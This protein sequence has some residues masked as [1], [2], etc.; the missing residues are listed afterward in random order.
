VLSL[1]IRQTNDLVIEIDDVAFKDD[2]FEFRATSDEEISKVYIQNVS[3]FEK[4]TYPVKHSQ[5][6]FAFSI[7]YDDIKSYPIRKWELK[8]EN[9]FKTLKLTRKFEF[10][11]EKNRVYII[12][13]RNKVMLSDDFYDSLD[14]LHDYSD[15]IADL[16]DS[17][18]DLKN[19]IKQ[20]KKELKQAKKENKS[21]K[22]KNSKLKEKNSELEN[23]MVNFSTVK[24]RLFKK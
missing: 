4:I 9:T 17:K 14:L 8:V 16:K 23:R 21:L 1:D 12:N 3:T 5:N 10:F 20:L 19:E 24:S 7:P 22:S 2:A 18:K 13:A 11:T 15:K 6:G